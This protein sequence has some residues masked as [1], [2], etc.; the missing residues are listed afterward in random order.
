ME[1]H[2]QLSSAL[3]TEHAFLH[4]SEFGATV[5][6]MWLNFGIYINKRHFILF[7]LNFMKWDSWNNGFFP[8]LTDSNVGWVGSPASKCLTCPVHLLTRRGY[9][10]CSFRDVKYLAFVKYLLPVF[11]SPWK[12]IVGLLLWKIIAPNHRSVSTRKSLKIR[13]VLYSRK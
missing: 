11:T 10:P 12:N 1:Y 2:E 4:C 5:A 3:N 13:K 6:K 7:Y 9:G 8:L